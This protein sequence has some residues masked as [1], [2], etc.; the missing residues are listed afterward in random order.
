MNNYFNIKTILKSLIIISS[1]N[2]F[3]SSP[4]LL[5][6]NFFSKLHALG[7]TDYSILITNNNGIDFPIFSD[8]KIKINNSRKVYIFESYNHTEG[9]LYCREFKAHKGITIISELIDKDH[10]VIAIPRNQINTLSVELNS[11]LIGIGRQM[12]Y[13]MKFGNDILAPIGGY[14][15]GY[16]GFIK[17]SAIGLIPATLFLEQPN[18]T[19]STIGCLAFTGL[20]TAEAAS[21]SIY[22]TNR[23]KMDFMEIPLSEESLWDISSSTAF[24]Y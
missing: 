24:K 5:I 22:A 3:L 11:E 10:K 1:I 7:I 15:A 2:I 17:A 19:I 13:N 18:P 14:A 6:N 16:F 20:V 9:I 21:H 8:T 12:G 23:I 4:N